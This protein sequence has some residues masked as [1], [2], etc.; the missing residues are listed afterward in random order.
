MKKKQMQQLHAADAEASLIKH[1]DN[2][3][4]GAVT[5]TA[6]EITEASPVDASQSWYHSKINP[7]T[8][9]STALYSWSSS[10]TYS[11]HF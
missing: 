11:F 7:L 6:G 4:Y 8:H 1:S 10:T 9:Y 2:I 3:N 5:S